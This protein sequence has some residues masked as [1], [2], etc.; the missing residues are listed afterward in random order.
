MTTAQAVAARQVPRVSRQR[1]FE[2]RAAEIAAW[3]DLLRSLDESEWHRPTVCTEWDVADIAGHL[4][5]QAEDVLVPWSFPVR[6]RRAAR[7]YPDVLLIDAHML[8]QADEHRGT[9][10]A[11]LVARFERLWQKANRSIRRRPGF[12]QAITITCDSIPIP[13]FQRL[14]L[15]YIQDVLLPRD[16][17]MHRD[18]V[19][20]ALG[21][22]FDAGA[23]A[24]Q[25]SAQVM[26]DVELSS[27][28][29][30]PPVRLVFTGP[31]GSSYVV[32]DG[33]P[34]ATVSTDAVGYMRTLSGRD[35]NPVVELIA[36]DPAGADAVARTRMPF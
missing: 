28:W 34:V 20:H 12:V 13:W 19:C 23:H 22:P 3:L 35:E 9:T 4:C 15:G 10:P 32:G 14:S 31:G 11:D 16:L 26:L 6:D 1:A 21:R 8:V 33:E 2:H 7:R 27:V 17:W 36:G 30:G 5:G 24:E 29:A 25:L 18:D